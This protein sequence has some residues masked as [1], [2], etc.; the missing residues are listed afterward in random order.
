[1]YKYSNLVTFYGYGPRRIFRHPL[2]NPYQKKAT[3][4][5]YRWLRKLK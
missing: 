3:Q 5:L 1:M 4:G 2:N